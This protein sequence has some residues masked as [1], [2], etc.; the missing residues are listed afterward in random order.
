VDL[1]LGCHCLKGIGAAS[2][3]DL[4]S[5]TSVLARISELESAFSPAQQQPTQSGSAAAPGSF[6]S[7]L[8]GA[9]GAKGADGADSA[10]GGTQ[11]PPGRYPHLSGDLGSN[12]VPVAK[13]GTSRHESGRAADVTIGGRPIQSVISAS[14]LRAAGLAPL[15]GDAV[16]VEL[17]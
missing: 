5:L 14:E 12:P 6:A 13:P 4:V 2:D 8:Q 1:A 11:A 3:Q 16:H 7:T 15:R 9:I 17:A 10:T